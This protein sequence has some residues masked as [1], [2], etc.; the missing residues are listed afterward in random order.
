MKA[1]AVVGYLYAYGDELQERSPRR[2]ALFAGGEGP[3]GEVEKIL[4]FV[5]RGG[6]GVSVG[7]RRLDGQGAFTRSFPKVGVPD[8]R[9][10]SY[11][12]SIIDLPSA[13]CWRLTVRQLGVRGRFAVLAFE[14]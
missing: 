8:A 13:G 9:G 3:N 6:A 10:G 1:G 12:A 5:R 4:W 2:A 7:G 11:Y 14:P